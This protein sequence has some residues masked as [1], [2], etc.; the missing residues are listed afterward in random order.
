MEP[1]DPLRLKKLLQPISSSVSKSS[2]SWIGS[3]IVILAAAFSI[4]TPYEGQPAAHQRVID[5]LFHN[6]F[7]M[8][9]I[10][11][12]LWL[13]RRGNF[14]SLPKL[15]RILYAPLFAFF[16]LVSMLDFFLW[17]PLWDALK[18]FGVVEVDAVPVAVMGVFAVWGIGIAVLVVRG[19]FRWFR[20]RYE[21]HGVA[22]GFGPLYFYFRRRRAS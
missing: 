13:A 15:L 19:T 1:E 11:A 9:A 5:S 20:R 10:T 4:L 22:V 3:T 6:W 17:R 21:H 16:L 2:R 8:S 18:P 14:G 12:A 7:A